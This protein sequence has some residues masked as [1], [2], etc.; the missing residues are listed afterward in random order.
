MAPVLLEGCSTVDKEEEKPHFQV[1][2]PI[3]EKEHL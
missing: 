1:I 3:A 2:L